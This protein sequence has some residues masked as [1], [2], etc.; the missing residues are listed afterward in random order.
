VIGS[1]NMFPTKELEARHFFISR[2]RYGDFAR[3]WVLDCCAAT[4]D[5]S[6]EFLIMIDEGL[7]R[8]SAQNGGGLELPVFGFGNTGAELDLGLCADDNSTRACDVESQ[9]S[10][11]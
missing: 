1:A 7:H 2:K 6:S 3:C 10:R 5:S 4:R 11:T 8:H 9:K